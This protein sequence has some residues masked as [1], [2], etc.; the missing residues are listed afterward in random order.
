MANILSKRN[1]QTLAGFASSNV[2]LAFD[3]DGTLAPIVSD[4]NMAR[5][6]PRT[7]RLLSAVA[8]RYPCVVI[9]GRARRD[10]SRRVGRVPV[11]H[12]SGNYGLEP[13][14]QDA[15]Y[16]SRV[17]EWV[18]LLE[19][20]LAPYRGVVVEDKTYSV[21]I[22]FRNARNRKA[23]R[24][25]IAAA[26]RSVRGARTMAGKHAVSLVPQGAPTKGVALA[27]ACRLLSCETAI[28]VGDDQTDEDAY[29]ATQPDRLLAIQVGRRRSRAHYRLENQRTIDD[30]LKALLALRPVRRT[31]RAGR[32]GQAGRAGS[33]RRVG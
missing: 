3:F 12:L 23:A 10:L 1:I 14:G 21:T 16:P 29:T 4:P 8:R 25:A 6:R 30:L 27:R 20:R 11:L 33:A 22:H 13:W 5:M 9:S 31:G 32:T 19:E 17:R 7:R 24:W 28:Y 2:L 15:S 18:R 26:V